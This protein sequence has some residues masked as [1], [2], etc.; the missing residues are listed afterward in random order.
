MVRLTA[1]ISMIELLNK[2]NGIT[3]QV[4]LEIDF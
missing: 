4:V 1:V 2:H 3:Y